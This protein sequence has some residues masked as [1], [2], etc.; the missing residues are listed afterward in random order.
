MRIKNQICCTYVFLLLLIFFTTKIPIEK[1]QTNAYESENQVIHWKMC[2][3]F[4]KHI[5]I[6]C[7]LLP[8]HQIVSGIEQS[9]DCL[10]LVERFLLRFFPRQTFCHSYFFKGRCF[11]ACVAFNF[12][13]KFIWHRPLCTHLNTQHMTCCRWKEKKQLIWFHTS[14]ENSERKKRAKVSERERENL[15]GEK[16]SSDTKRKWKMLLSAEILTHQCNHQAWNKRRG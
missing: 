2:S 4:N 11:F 9:G 13:L 3:F 1:T 10:K 8:T 14:A 15:S 6:E 12:T 16:E 5:H 7:A